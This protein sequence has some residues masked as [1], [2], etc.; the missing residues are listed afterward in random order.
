[1][2]RERRESY[3]SGLRLFM[4]GMYELYNGTTHGNLGLY[5]TNMYYNIIYISKYY[6]TR[7]DKKGKKGKSGKTKT[8]RERDG[9]GL[10]YFIC[11]TVW[12]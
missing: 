11:N 3:E 1:M 8:E 12:L 9:I 7:K 2:S 5:L 6:N 10:C 4:F